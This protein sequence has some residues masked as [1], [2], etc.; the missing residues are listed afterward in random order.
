MHKFF[1][2]YN[3]L[4]QRYELSQRQSFRNSAIIQAENTLIPQIRDNIQHLYENIVLLKEQEKEEKRLEIFDETELLISN[5]YYSLFSSPL[6]L[7]ED[8]KIEASLQNAK[9]LI[10]E[11]IKDINIPEHNRLCILIKNNIESLA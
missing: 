8:N 5:L 10:N 3:N 6:E 1:C 7:V 4:T 9:I 11:L 2:F